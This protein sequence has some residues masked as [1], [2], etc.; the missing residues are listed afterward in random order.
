MS[1]RGFNTFHGPDNGPP[2]PNMPPG[3][4]MYPQPGFVTTQSQPQY[5]QPIAGVQTV[6]W[7][8]Y[9][10]SGHPWTNFA[11][12]YGVASNHY[13]GPGANPYMPIALPNSEIPGL[14]FRNPSGGIGL[15]PGYDYLFPPEHTVIHVFRPSQTTSP[16]WQ[17]QTSPLDAAKFFKFFVPCNLTIL[18]LMGRLGLD[19]PDA[20]MNV[21]HEVV[22][23]G[24]GW[25]AKGISVK[26]DDKDRLK[27]TLKDM[28]WD[29]S[30]IGV[31]GKRPVVWLY[32]TKK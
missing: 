15:P 27:K 22:E 20:K 4:G 18:E 12:Y 29:S 28:G 7:Q 5:S 31:P 26:G 8:I 10:G 17:S 25:W 16:P 13:A 24:G 6:P 1:G 9:Q 2:P 30:R 3:H 19:N 23:K 14:N 11:A 32:I 21:V